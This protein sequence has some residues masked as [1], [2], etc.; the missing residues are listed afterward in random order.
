MS[1]GIYRLPAGSSDPQGPHNE[2]E[3]YYVIAGRATLTAGGESQPVQTGSIAFVPAR[4][5]HRFENIEEDLEVLV[6]FAPAE[7]DA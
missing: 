2:D 4:E 6:F 5:A 1:A 3:T 7:T